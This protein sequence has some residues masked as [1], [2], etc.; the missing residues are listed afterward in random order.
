MKIKIATILIHS[1]FA[2]SYLMRWTQAVG[3]ENTEFLQ[4]C[5]TQATKAG[6]NSAM[7]KEETTSLKE[8]FVSSPLK[9]KNKL[10]SLAAF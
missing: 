7:K 3:G 9:L 4:Q 10:E 8:G 2:L 6:S 5:V 1:S